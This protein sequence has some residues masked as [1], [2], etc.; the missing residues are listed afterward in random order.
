MFLLAFYELKLTS[1]IFQIKTP[2][3]TRGYV[4]IYNIDICA[5]H[6]NNNDN[7]MY[8][9]KVN[10]FWGRDC[11]LSNIECRITFMNGNW[12]TTLKNLTACHMVQQNPHLKT[13]V[14]GGKALRHS[15]I[16]VCYKG[17]RG[18]SAVNCSA[19]KSSTLTS[20]NFHWNSSFTIG[21][22][23]VDNIHKQIT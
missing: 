12:I 7:N 6:N 16:S 15:D 11:K 9:Y 22:F 21:G 20:S 14:K 3:I 19:V 5:I 8:I 2:I 17:H 1:T 10:T 23:C 18:Q 13:T 4:D